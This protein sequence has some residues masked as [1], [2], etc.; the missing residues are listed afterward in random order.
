MGFL[1]EEKD[2]IVWRGLMVSLGTLEI[3]PQPPCP[4]TPPF[5]GDVSYSE[6]VAWCG[7][8]AAGCALSGHATRN[9]RYSAHHITASACVRLDMFSVVNH[10][11]IM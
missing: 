5:V 3:F 9:W 7:V 4:L 8:G 11:T 2:A 1:V 10:V 6:A